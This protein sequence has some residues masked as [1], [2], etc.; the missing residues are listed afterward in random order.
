MIDNDTIIQWIKENKLKFIKKHIHSIDFYANQPVISQP[1]MAACYWG[2]TEIFN[3]FIEHGLDVNYDFH[4]RNLINVCLM[5]G[6]TSEEIIVYLCKN[7]NLVHQTFDLSTKLPFSYALN[8][9]KSLAKTILSYM[10]D[11]NVIDNMGNTILMDAISN[12]NFTDSLKLIAKKKK[13]CDL[14]IV[15]HK[16]ETTFQLLMK[17]KMLTPEVLDKFM[18]YFTEEQI[19]K[20]S[21]HEGITFNALDYS[22]Y[23]GIRDKKICLKLA[24]LGL[25][26][27]DFKQDTTMTPLREDIE[28]MYLKFKLESQLNAKSTE[29]KIKI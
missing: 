10:K 25:E 13:K 29:R 18:P 7:T 12:G 2:K 8:K 4:G 16:G 17:L 11:I 20:E 22:Y 27:H 28:N 21:V 23:F 9:N 14:N 19:L 5:S 26:L 15:N 1:V 24:S 3:L 6:K